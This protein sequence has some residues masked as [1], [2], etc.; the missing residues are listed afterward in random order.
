M[1]L[2]GVLASVGYLLPSGLLGM[3][4]NW[5]NILG[6]E[7]ADRIDALEKR[8]SALEKPVDAETEAGV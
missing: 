7:S 2:A 8:V 5:A 6:R 3:A 1:I 4:R